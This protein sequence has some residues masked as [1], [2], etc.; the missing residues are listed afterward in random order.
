MTTRPTEVLDRVQKALRATYTI[1][2]ELGGGGMS[3]V[4]LAEER[5]LG[6][7][8]VIKLLSP[9]LAEGMSADRFEREI[10]LVARLQHPHI[11]PLFSA[12]TMDGIPYY[13]MPY[14]DGESLRAK[15]NREKKLEVGEA[16]QVLRDVACALQYA[17][18]HGV[19]HRDIKPDNILLSGSSACVADF[20]IARAVTVART[21][22]HQ[23]DHD[24]SGSSITR[25]GIAVGTPAYMS[26]EQATCSSEIDHR[27]D[28]YS[29]GCVAF[30]LLTGEPPFR[31]KGVQAMLVAQVA[32]AAPVARLRH[33]GIPHSLAALVTTCLEK[34]PARRP[35]SAADLISVF[36]SR[37]SHAR[38]G[39]SVPERLSSIAVLPFENM[40]GDRD[41]EF[42]SDGI[43]EEIINSLTQISGLRVAG[44][45]SSFAFK[46]TKVDLATIGEKLNVETVLE[47]SVRKAGNQLRITAQLVKISDGY[48][49][50][51]ERFDRDLTDVFEVQD[52]IATAI[53]SK[54]KLSM[55]RSDEFVKTPTN[56]VRAYE[57]F[58]KARQLYY[59]PGWQL[60]QAIRLFEEAL[61]L[62]DRFGLAH[63]GLADAL[64]L[65]GYYGLVK[66]AEIIDRAHRAAVRAVELAPDNSDAH[67]AVALWTTFYG[68]DRHTAVYAW[69]KVASGTAV[70]TQVRCSY[71][72]FGLG[73]MAG[74]WDDG[75]EEIQAA[76][77]LDPLNGFAHAMLAMLKTFAGQ[78]GDVVAYARRG[79]ELDS[80]SFWT[81]LTLQRAL[82]YAG[83]HQEAQ[84]QG[85]H[86]LEISGRHPWSLA[87]LAVDYASVG[88]R[89]GAEA[90]HEE[91]AARGKTRELQP[92]VLA[93]VAIAAGHF[94]EA[95]DYC[96]RAIRER[97]AHILWAVREVWD[98]WQ[99][100][101]A[102][103]GWKDVRKGIFT[104]RL[105]PDSGAESL[106]LKS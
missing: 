26:P 41:N 58:L 14:I 29:F 72:L 90:I 79:V 84:Q 81:H 23:T 55:D 76:I 66:P 95:I 96:N 19:I 74:R 51:S 5:A 61:K 71:A 69:E 43:S 68:G 28:I 49:L 53:A 8:V 46:G 21:G 63:A 99:P 2:R 54:L 12:G 7:T 45:T 89:S 31:K 3:R 73:L 98:G 64:T 70:R 75:V 16:S 80:G 38:G 56:N 30:E 57:L 62:D 37:M 82:H 91:L 40:S 85:L 24:G 27:A 101:Y 65:S 20:G 15:L 94:D 105:Q 97:D 22:P 67:H 35:A 25:H 102:H 44:R 1:L 48:H 39:S 4:F 32:E 104:W 36:D 88:N 60:P 93:L 10:S 106:Q 6:R 13:T 78:L 33:P 18:G 47:G 77:A 87:E 83:M 100:L 42:F 9:D 52:E 86:T 17:H 103:P 11:V 92:S 34:D 59:L 50:W